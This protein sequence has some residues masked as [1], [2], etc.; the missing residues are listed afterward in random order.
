MVA[1]AIRGSHVTTLG[2]RF[3]G[4]CFAPQ[5]ND[6]GGAFGS[7]LLTGRQT[8]ANIILLFYARILYF[9]FNYYYYYYLFALFT[10]RTNHNIFDYK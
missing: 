4:V 6:G 2:V 10:H 5:A 7:E 8:H 9:M 3:C 1:V